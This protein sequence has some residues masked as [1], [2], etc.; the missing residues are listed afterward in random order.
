MT[1]VEVDLLL[2]ALEAALHHVVLLVGGRVAEAHP[3]QEPVELGLGQRVGALVLDRVRGRQHV[4]GVGQGERLALHGRL[5][6]LHR[7]QQRRLG[8]RRR[9][10]DLVGEHQ[11]GEQRTATELEAALL[12][13]VEE[14]AGDVGRQQVGGELHPREVQAQHPGQAPRRQGLAEPGEVLEQHVALGQDGREH[15]RE[16]QRACR[17]PPSRPRR[18]PPGPARTPRRPTSPLRCGSVMGS[19]MGT[20]P[21]SVGCTPRSRPAAGCAAGRRGHR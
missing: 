10:V 3:H 11:P 9:P 20:A 7:L 19:V 2:L 14:G 4:E 18:A 1:C 21:R 17:R 16:R 6:L 13:V 12:L 5:P 15:Q 8:L